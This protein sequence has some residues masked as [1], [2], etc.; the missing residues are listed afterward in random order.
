MTEKLFYIYNI[1]LHLRTHA[2]LRLFVRFIPL[3]HET[4]ALS[5][6]CVICS[7]II[8]NTNNNLDPSRP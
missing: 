4:Q 8:Y 1:I 2:G 3:S 7:P 6:S 5:L